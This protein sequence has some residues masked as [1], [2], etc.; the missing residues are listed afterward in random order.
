[1]N[2]A[3]LSGPQSGEFSIIGTPAFPITLAPSTNYS[4]Q[5]AVTPLTTGIRNANLIISSD[6]ADENPYVFALQASGTID[7]GINTITSNENVWLYPNPAQDAVT[8]KVQDHK[9]TIQV[10]IMNLLGEVLFNTQLESGQTELKI[11][12]HSMVSGL[13]LVKLKQDSGY[14]MQNL[15]ISK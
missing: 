4:L 3:V 12:T 1:I 15:I 5:L 10:S 8:L 13:Y 14:T 11:Q 7:V 6:D 2:S 9:E